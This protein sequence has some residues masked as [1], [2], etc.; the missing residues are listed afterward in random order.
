MSSLSEGEHWLQ[1][2]DWSIEDLTRVARQ[3]NFGRGEEMA[4]SLLRNAMRDRRIDRTMAA[5]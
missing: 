1:M 3:Q 5:K 2:R 4:R